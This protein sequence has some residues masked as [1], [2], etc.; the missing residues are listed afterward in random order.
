[1][2]SAHASGVVTTETTTVATPVASASA[3]ATGVPAELHLKYWP[4]RGLMEVPR[5]MLAMSGKFPG[6]YVD[7]RYGS[8]DGSYEA[9]KTE[10]DANLGRMPVATAEGVSVGQSAAINFYVASKCDMMGGSIMEAAQIIAI[11]EHLSEMKTAYRKFA[12][13]GEEPTEENVANWFVKGADG[14]AADITGNADM[15]NRKRTMYWWSQRIESQVGA[16]GF[17]VGS[18]PSL[19]DVLIYNSFAETLEDAQAKDGIAQYKKEPFGH[20]A[21]T[22]AALA[23]CPKL[24][25]IVAQVA[26]NAGFQ[27]H[28]ATRGVQN[29]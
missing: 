18:A 5:V 27:K 7:G 8:D 28:L 12:A 13:Y 4:G 19:A 14:S 26:S 21:H 2:T 3:S 24:S 1:V 17:A 23:S 9:H 22:D 6:D 20:K 10:F 16:G 25:A 29:F 15:G 11:Q